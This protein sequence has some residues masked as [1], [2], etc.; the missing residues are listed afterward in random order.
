MWDS[1]YGDSGVVYGF[2]AQSAAYWLCVA[3]NKKTTFF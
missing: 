2:E 1:P 3:F